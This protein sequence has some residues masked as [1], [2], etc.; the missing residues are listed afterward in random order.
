MIIE[1]KNLVS[2][3]STSS[4]EPLDIKSDSIV[5]ITVIDT[6]TYKLVN[7]EGDGIIS[8]TNPYHV[9]NSN[10]I[11]KKNDYQLNFQLGTFLQENTTCIRIKHNKE[12]APCKSWFYQ[13]NIFCFC[14]E[15]GSVLVVENYILTQ[16]SIIMQFYS[17]DLRLCNIDYYNYFSY[18]HF[19]IGCCY[20]LQFILVCLSES[21]VEQK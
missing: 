14:N 1:I 2:N 15:Q 11:N 9:I 8:N 10:S 18:L 13:S 12:I 16:E 21:M 5:N 7:Q 6:Q 3:N 17:F 19:P 4:F 20:I